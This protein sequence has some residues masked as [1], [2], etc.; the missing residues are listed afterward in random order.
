MPLL[1]YTS[2]RS[3]ISHVIHKL[4]FCYIHPHNFVADDCCNSKQFHYCCDNFVGSYLLKSP[5]DYCNYRKCCSCSTD[6]GHIQ[7]RHISFHY[8]RCFAHQSVKETHFLGYSTFDRVTLKFI[9]LTDCHILK[10]ILKD[11]HLA[12]LLV[13]LP[14]LYQAMLIL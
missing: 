11:F 13:K 14:L 8:K 2:I 5:A 6:F 12:L 7:V 1:H 10:E 9:N 4:R 3:Y